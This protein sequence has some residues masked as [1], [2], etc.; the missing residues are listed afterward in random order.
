[1]VDASGLIDRLRRPEYTGENRCEPCTLLNAALA[2]A[3]SAALFAVAPPLALAFLVVAGAAIYLRGYLV[4]GTPTLTRRYLPDRFLAAFGKAPAEPAASTDVEGYLTEVG[5]VEPAGDDLALT[6]AFREAW[7]ERMA[8]VSAGPAASAA[9][10]LDLDGA[11]VRERGD[12]FVVTEDDHTV[13]EWPSRPALVADLA[14]AELLSER[15]P[16]WA[17]ADR[18]TQGRRLTGLRVFLET[19]PACG[20]TPVLSEETVESCCRSASVYTYACPDC[21][22]R[23]LELES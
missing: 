5:A 15:D 4:P 6:P 20:G 22:A 18:T 10:L 17:A 14:A 11:S 1:M 9:D 16:A 8:S 19:C 21:D 3:V 23:L 13:A 2:V 7:T 12:A